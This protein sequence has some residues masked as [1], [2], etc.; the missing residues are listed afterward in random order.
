MP[1]PRKCRRVEQIP[2]YTFF[3]PAGVPLADLFEVELTVEELEAVRL[4]DFLGLEHEECAQKMLVSRPTFQRILAAARRKIAYVLVKGA[5]LKV[6][7][8]DFELAESALECLSCGHR[9]RGPACR[10]HTACPAC[11]SRDWRRA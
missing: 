2:G 11:A 3:K 7:G 1:R 9:W 6:A 5:A 10:R 4:R 8:G